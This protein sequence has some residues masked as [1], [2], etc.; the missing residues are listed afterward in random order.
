MWTPVKLN[1][2]LTFPYGIGWHLYDHRGFKRI[3]VNGATGTN[4]TRFLEEKLTV[5]VLTNLNRVEPWH[6]AL[7]VAGL[8]NPGLLPPYML[9]EQP[10]SDPKR[11]QKLQDFLVCVAHG[12]EFISMTA[13]LRAIIAQLPGD[14]VGSFKDIKSL[15]FLACDEVA[16][17]GVEMY[18]ASV[19]RI[20]HY[21]VVTEQETLYVE[22]C[23]TEEGKLADFRTFRDYLR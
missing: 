3:S 6:L 10:D 12:K 15:A 8:Y 7:G 22:F 21:K 17:R 2:G 19:S 13:G 4:I 16:E 14:Q 23:L 9:Q 5:I 20:C 11:T 1:N 18:G